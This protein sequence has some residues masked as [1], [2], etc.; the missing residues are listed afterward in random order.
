MRLP[1][2]GV[3]VKGRT[4]LGVWLRTRPFHAP[5]PS[6]G[7]R[8]ALAAKLEALALSAERECERAC[9]SDGAPNPYREAM[10]QIKAYRYAAQLARAFSDPEPEGAAQALREAF[11]A[12]F[13]ASGEGYN[14]EYLRLGTDYPACN[15]R[16]F[17]EFLATRASAPSEPEG[18]EKA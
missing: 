13:E 7:E 8:N 3:V 6:Q 11:D 5:A 2:Y 16:Y 14:G 1:R 12:G 15:D 18:G 10:A 17:A 4:R 9:L